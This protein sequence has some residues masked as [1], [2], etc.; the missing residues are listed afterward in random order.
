MKIKSSPVL[1]EQLMFSTYLGLLTVLD[2]DGV[3]QY[4]ASDITMPHNYI[5]GRTSKIRYLSQCSYR[6][7]AKS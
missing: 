7:S 3:S 6:A 1:L 5:F 2:T 4:R